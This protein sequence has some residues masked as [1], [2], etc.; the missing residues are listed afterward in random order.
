MTHGL[1]HALSRNH[2]HLKP[3][4]SLCKPPLQNSKTSINRKLHGSQFPHSALNSSC[5]KQLTSR[6]TAMPTL[7]GVSMIG[8]Q[9]TLVPSLSFRDLSQCYTTTMLSHLS[10]KQM[11]STPLR[12]AKPIAHTSKSQHI[13]QIAHTRLKRDPKSLNLEESTNSVS[14]HASMASQKWLSTALPLSGEPYSLSVRVK[15]RSNTRSSLKLVTLSMS[16]RLICP[17]LAQMQ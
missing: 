16:V 3:K 12:A 15:L 5:P 9:M 17:R 10:H 11:H 13:S 2:L 1:N 7:T 14:K 4:P 8:S 6:P